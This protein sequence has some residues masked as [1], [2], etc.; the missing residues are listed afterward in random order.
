MTGRSLIR[1]HERPGGTTPKH[2]RSARAGLSGLRTADKVAK[3][4]LVETKMTGNASFPTPDP[5]LLVLK[6]GREKLELAMVAA[7]TGDHTKIFERNVAEAELDQLLVRESL[8]VSNVAN[9][10]AVIILSSGF[11]LR[12]EP[13]PIGPL[14]APIELRAHAGLLPG[15]VNVRWKPV[16]GAYYYQVYVSDKD[17]ND[18]GTWQLVG[19]TSAASFDSTGNKAAT[20]V[21]YRV[22]CLG[23]AGYVSPYSDPAKGFAAPN[24]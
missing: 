3:A 22:N 24:P 4:L 15:D 13:A 7:A 14:P 1:K 20:Y 12:K 2:M 21:W 9:G 8:Y 23:A 5:T 19:M 17:P 6:A 18:G 11:E 10:D 16:K